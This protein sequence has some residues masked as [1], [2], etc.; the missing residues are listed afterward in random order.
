MTK[1]F[2]VPDLP[3]YAKDIKLNLSSLFRPG[4]TPGLAE[5][6]AAGVALASAIASRNGDYTAQVQAF[7][8]DMLDES[9]VHAVKAAAAVMAMNNIYYR[10]VHLVED[11]EYHSLPARLRMNV[12]R[13]PGVAPVDF[14]LYSLAVSAINGCGMCVRSHER[15]LR[16]HGITREGVQSAVRVAAVVH[17]AAVTVE[18]ASHERSTDTDQAA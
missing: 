18:Q 7:V 8:A 1:A 2:P 5:S 16:E 3:D 12:L 17:A 14:E 11:A 9:A 10:F 13:S 15:S 6:Q 4:G